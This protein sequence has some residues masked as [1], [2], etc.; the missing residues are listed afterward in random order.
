MDASQMNYWSLLRDMLVRERDTLS[1]LVILEGR[2]FEAL[3]KVDI[4]KIIMINSQ[5][6]DY[7]QKMESIEKKR[8]EILLILSKHHHFD[9]DV[10]IT[11]LI[12]S[13]P[14]ELEKYKDILTD[15]R[16]AIKSIA[17]NLGAA[18]HENSRII[19]TNLEIIN[20][21][22]NFAN[23]G[24]QKETYN[25]NNKKVNRSNLFLINQIA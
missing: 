14:A 10:T 8:K 25:Y 21:T 12:E 9:S 20:A 5:E 19:K 24:D 13:I 4:S 23:K 16:L 7:L 6:E 2:K 1:E 22:L 11:Q 18:L 3:K 15:L 17:D